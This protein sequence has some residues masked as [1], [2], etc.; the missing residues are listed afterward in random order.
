MW[1]CWILYGLYFK[2]EELTVCI[3]DQ[4]EVVLGGWWWTEDTSSM[5]SFAFVFLEDQF[6]ILTIILLITT[7]LGLWRGKGTKSDFITL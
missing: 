2:E 1:H 7:F 3:E 5:M 6:H 4:A